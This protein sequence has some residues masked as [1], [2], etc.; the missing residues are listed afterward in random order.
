[1]IIEITQAERLWARKV[2]NQEMD[3]TTQ[4]K[5]NQYCKTKTDLKIVSTINNRLQLEW[6]FRVVMNQYWQTATTHNSWT[7]W[8]QIHQID[9]LQKSWM[10]KFKIKK[11]S[12]N[13]NK[14][15][16]KWNTWS[17]MFM[18]QNNSLEWIKIPVLINL[19]IKIVVKV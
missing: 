16:D 3:Q 14:N 1:M 13:S 5:R 8:K 6:Q 18:E 17:S 12:T 4:A 9:L 10:N 7:L 19:L 15:L 2:K 11:G